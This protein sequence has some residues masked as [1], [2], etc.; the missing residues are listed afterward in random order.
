MS[1]LPSGRN[2]YATVTSFIVDIDRVILVALF[3]GDRRLAALDDGSR[4]AYHCPKGQQPRSNF[5]NSLA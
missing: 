5:W 1:S 3:H 2:P 4:R